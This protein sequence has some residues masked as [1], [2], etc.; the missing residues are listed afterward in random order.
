MTELYDEVES[1]VA[2]VVTEAV[3]AFD[4]DTV[5]VI[6]ADHVDGHRVWDATLIRQQTN[7][8]PARGGAVTTLEFWTGE[9]IELAASDVTSADF[10][11]RGSDTHE[12]LTVMTAGD[13]PALL[14][15]VPQG[16]LAEKYRRTTP[17][18]SVLESDAVKRC[19]TALG[20]LWTTHAYHDLYV[21]DERR[22]GPEGPAAV[23]PITGRFEGVGR[24]VNGW[25]VALGEHRIAIPYNVNG[26]VSRKKVMATGATALVMID[27]P[28]GRIF[29]SET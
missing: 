19:E 21:R 6:Q 26:A 29:I 9:R 18:R 16:A 25:T 24:D 11:R 1:D 13:V 8:D 20:Y 10:G 5:T 27:A 28:G 12:T 14:M 7:H 23:E 22:A 4:G 17:P 3:A 2:S 15:I